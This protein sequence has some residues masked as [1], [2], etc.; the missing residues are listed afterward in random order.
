MQTHRETANYI[1]ASS[2]HFRSLAPGKLAKMRS[3]DA[4]DIGINIIINMSVSIQQQ[5]QQC[6]IFLL[7]TF[8]GHFP[9]TKAT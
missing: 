7:C 8:P 5:Q 6:S 2:R 1:H 9:L 4:A 3:N